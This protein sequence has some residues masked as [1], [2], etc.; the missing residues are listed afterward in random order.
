MKQFPKTKE[1][2]LNYVEEYFI[3]E[4]EEEFQLKAEI[5]KCSPSAPLCINILKQFYDEK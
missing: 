3:A 1:S 4:T 2:N 5:S